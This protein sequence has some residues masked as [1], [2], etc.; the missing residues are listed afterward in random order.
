MRW[1]SW[2]GLAAAGLAGVRAASEELLFYDDMKYKE[3]EIAANELG[4]P[5]TWLR[6]VVV[7]KP[8]NLASPCRVQG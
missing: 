4:I 3:Y 8:A 2:A 1:A 7:D 6:H 5:S